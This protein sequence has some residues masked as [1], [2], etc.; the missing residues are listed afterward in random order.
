MSQESLAEAAGIDRTYVSL[1][2]RGLRKPT[3]DVAER[4]SNALGMRLPIL[5]MEAE[6]E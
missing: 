2:E 5:L 1:V 4:L 6:E 3:L